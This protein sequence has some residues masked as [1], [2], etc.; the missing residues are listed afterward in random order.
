MLIHALALAAALVIDGGDVEMR[1]PARYTLCIDGPGH[2]AACGTGEPLCLDQRHHV[3]AA[4]SHVL[5]E[6]QGHSYGWYAVQ[7]AAGLAADTLTT[8]IAIHRGGRE[9]NP[10]LPTLEIRLGA[11]TLGGIGVAGLLW[12]LD[13]QMHH[14]RLAKVLTFA[15]DGFFLALSAHN[16]AVSR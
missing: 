9:A 5:H 3:M 6:D 2:L 11:K 4:C 8:G 14:P 16:L 12:T 1:D 13:H 15:L 10:V 7:L